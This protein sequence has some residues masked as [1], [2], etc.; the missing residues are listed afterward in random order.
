M[1]RTLLLLLPALLP[2]WRFFKTIEPSPRVEWALTTAD[3]ALP[4]RWHA[5]RPPPR[6]V[7]PL[8]M[9]RRMLWNPGWNEAL[10]LVSCAERLMEGPNAHAHEE[11]F[12]RVR[13]DVIQA[14]A[15]SPVLLQFRLVF[16][17]R[18]G[19]QLMREVTYQSEARA[20]IPADNP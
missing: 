9:A 1:L 13:A 8:A 14:G 4:D 18:E 16:V 12:R 5:Y 17:S 15:V 2:S 7:P 20:L 3:G 6:H 11:I 10:Y 19:A